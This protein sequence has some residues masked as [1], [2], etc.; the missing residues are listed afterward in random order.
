MA[1]DGSTAWEVHTGGSDTNGGGFGGNVATGITNFSATLATSTAPI[2]TSVSYTFVAGDV[3][4][5]LFIKSGTNW[6]PGWY[7]ITGISGGGAVVDAAVGHAILYRPSMG[8]TG[9][10]YNT[11]AGIATVA[12]PTSGTGGVDYCQVD[13]TVAL[14]TNASSAT[15]TLTLSAPGFTPAMVGNVFFLTGTG[16]TPGWYQMT[17]YSST[18]ICTI[19]RSAGATGSAI[20]VNMGG[21]LASPGQAAANW[22]GNNSIW[23]KTGTYTITTASTNV[24]GGCLAPSSAGAIFLLSG[25]GTVRGDGVSPPTLILNTG[26]STATFITPTAAANVKNLI[27]DGHAE[28]TSKGYSGGTANNGSVFQNVKFQNFTSNAF[29]GGNIFHLAVGCQFTGCTLTSSVTGNFTTFIGCEAY[30]NTNTPFGGGVC[31]DCLSY[32]NSGASTDGFTGGTCVNCVAYNNGR[33]GFFSVNFIINCHAENNP[34]V[35]FNFPNSQVGYSSG[36]TA[37]GNGAPSSGA[38]TPLTFFNIPVT[39]LSSSPF[40]SAATGD[41]SLN[42]NAGGGAVLRAAAFPGAF[43]RGLTTGYLDIGAVQH[44]DVA[45]ASGIPFVGIIDGLL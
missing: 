37:F 43:P 25:F 34:T 28:T 22:A 32:N 7:K 41:F 27:L 20:T 21:A 3:N 14:D 11:V 30:S 23:I 1:I 19:D 44:G 4:S 18:T 5:W 8:G 36:C 42:N 17:A 12:S 10:F 45:P 2:V 26:V 9:S 13:A 35:G 40:N 38:V 29:A 33:D 15:T 31:V 16:I 39:S 24:S 6:T